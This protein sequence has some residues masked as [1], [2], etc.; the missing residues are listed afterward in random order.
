MSTRFNKRFLNF[1]RILAFSIDPIKHVLVRINKE[2]T[3]RN[4]S[5]VEGSP[6]YIM[7]WDFNKYSSGMH[8]LHVSA[9]Y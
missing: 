2:Y 7:E 8:E 6:L 9:D 3:W 1:F 4:C 5:N